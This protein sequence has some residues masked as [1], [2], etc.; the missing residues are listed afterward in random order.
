MAGA[1]RLVEDIAG[2][3]PPP[4]SSASLTFVPGRS[5]HIV[6]KNDQDAALRGGERLSHVKVNATV[7]SPAQAP[8]STCPFIR[9]KAQD[10]RRTRHSGLR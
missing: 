9:M 3:A 10:W 1:I 5:A 8:I 2:E 7:C 6:C 4:C